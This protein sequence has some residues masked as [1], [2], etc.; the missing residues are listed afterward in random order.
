M[1]LENS[2]LAIPVISVII[3]R[4][5][6]GQKEILIQTRVSGYDKLFSGC[7]EI[8]AGKIERFESVY[9]TIRREVKE[10]TGL[11]VVEISPKEEKQLSVTNNKG[12]AVVFHPF[13]AQQLLKGNIPW[14]GFVFLCKVAEGEVKEAVGE[15]KDVRWV[16][17]PELRSLVED[18]ADEIFTLQLPVLEYYLKIID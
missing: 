15:T 10:E 2:P 18:R 14:V 12:T 11:D 3:E 4:E 5:A 16:T 13:C 1:D 8:P 17:I 9:E 7:I 6:N